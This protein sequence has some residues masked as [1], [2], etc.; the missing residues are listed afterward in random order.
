MTNSYAVPSERFDDQSYI[1]TRVAKAAPADQS[2]LRSALNY[3]YRSNG[4]LNLNR[5]HMKAA[6]AYLDPGEQVVM[7]WLYTRTNG[8]LRKTYGATALMAARS[9]RYR[10]ETCSFDDVRVLNLDHVKGRVEGTPFACLCANCH[11]IKSRQFDW[12]GQKRIE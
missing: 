5:A 3:L 11:T 7:R 9:A 2:A 1:E 6:T 12:N 4:P 10:C 8:S